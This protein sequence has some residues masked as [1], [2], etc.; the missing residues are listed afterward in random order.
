MK[1]LILIKK[2]IVVILAF[3]LILS[4]LPAAGLTG[5]RALAADIVDSGTCGE[6]LTWT[7]DSDGLLTISGT[8]ATEKYSWGQSPFYENDKIRKV[9]I[10]DG[11]T[12]LE[13]SLFIECP[14]LTA[15]V[16]PDTLTRIASQSFQRTALTSVTIP[17]SV[18]DLDYSAISDSPNISAIDVAP[19]NPVFHS[20]DNCVIETEKKSLHIG[21]KTS[22]IPT[23]GSVI[24][25]GVGAFSVCGCPENVIIPDCVTELEGA[26]FFECG[27]IK[28]LSIGAGVTGIG[29][30]AL[31]RC[32]GL[33][34]ISVAAE[35]TAYRSEDGV[36]FDRDKTELILYPTQKTG[37]AYTIPTGVT[38]IWDE[39][40]YENPYLTSVV[41][42]DGVTEIG[43]YA[44]R[45][46]NLASFNVPDSVI[47]LGSGVFYGSAWY[48]AQPDGVV[49]AG[50]HAC[51]FKGGD[52]P[53]DLIFRDGTRGISDH[54]IYFF[55]EA[56]ETVTIP[57][58]VRYIGEYAFRGCNNLKVLTMPAGA[59]TGKYAFPLD[60][61]ETVTLTGSGDMSDYDFPSRYSE[62]PSPFANAENLRAVTIADGVT[63]VGSY[64][65]ADCSSLE[66]VTLSDTVSSIG[67][68]SFLNCE[69]LKSVKIPSSLTMVGDSA[70][71]G[72]SGLEAVYVADLETW[73]GIVFYS[74]SSNPLFYA[75]K[76]YVG[77]EQL[78]ELTVPSGVTTIGNYAFAGCSGL[79][80]ATI[81]EGVTRIGNHAFSSCED[82]KS[83]TIPASATDVGYNLFE[84]CK[85]LERISLADPAVWCGMEFDYYDRDN[86]L[87]D[88]AKLYVGGEPLTKL[89]IPEGVTG[90]ATYAFGGYTD[91][92]SLTIPASVTVIGRDA[93]RGCTNLTELIVE[94]AEKRSVGNNAFEG[95]PAMLDA[96]STDDTVAVSALKPLAAS[97]SLG[98]GSL[99]ASD[100]VN[101]DAGFRTLGLWFAQDD[102]GNENK[103]I[104]FIDGDSI[105]HTD[106][107]AFVAAATGN[108][109]ENCF[110]ME[111]V[112]A[113]GDAFI[114]AAI[115]RIYG[116]TEDQW[117]YEVQFLRT[118]DGK[119]AERLGS[120]VLSDSIMDNISERN[121]IFKLGDSYILA[122]KYDSFL[123]YDHLILDEEELRES[124]GC[125]IGLQTKDFKTFS[126]FE[127][128]AD[129][130]F[131]QKLA[132]IRTENGS[133]VVTA[134][135]DQLTM[136]FDGRLFLRVSV[137]PEHPDFMLSATPL[138][139]L[140]YA[141]D[142]AD[143]APKLIADE[144]VR[145]DD[146]ETM[147]EPY[148]LKTGEIM[149]SYYEATENRYFTRHTAWD[150][151]LDCY[152]SGIF[153]LYND[154]GN[155]NA[156]LINYQE[157][158]V[159]IDFYRF[160]D[161]APAQKMFRLSGVDAFVKKV[162]YSEKYPFV[163]FTHGILMVDHDKA[164]YAYLN[165]PD[166]S[167]KDVLGAQNGIYVLDTK[168]DAYYISQDEFVFPAGGEPIPPQPTDPQPT[169]PQPTD[170]QPT[171]PQ[172][173]DPPA[174]DAVFSFGGE[175]I[176][177][178]E[179][180]EFVIYA[181]AA[182]LTKSQ[183]VAAITGADNAVVTVK[184]KDG[185][186]LADDA[187]PGTGS[188]V[189]VT[190]GESAVTKTIIFLGDVDGDATVNAT[191]ARLALRAA[192]K[193]DT[194]DGAF[195]SAADTDGD[196]NINATDA[197]GILRAAAK[198][199]VLTVA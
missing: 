105:T 67:Q 183:L 167:V 120:F 75:H 55:G 107:A 178:A 132:E 185:N 15:V 80:S 165:M 54:F 157:I 171:D 10:G 131:L 126:R 138:K 194:L 125:R 78:T 128:K 57:D 186:E 184:D 83:V 68:M 123:S 69:K 158:P 142:S 173:T 109:E 127:F 72:C 81:P 89:V 166:I 84:G 147:I 140:Y 53:S 20:V 199:D 88:G 162:V 50:K 137:W 52:I 28:T 95:V 153:G 100:T 1:R 168:G 49:Y 73:C 76:L 36:L 176:T 23:D 154:K 33:T 93:F 181:S 117:D 113:D 193:L 16:F 159:S 24:K 156:I 160:S 6:N 124:G 119:T 13:G 149:R 85:A 129:D 133:Q 7:L 187:T 31:Y 18:T 195:A 87:A 21:C 134:A 144:A 96:A 43:D 198:L 136:G 161:D 150:L 8:G 77:G 48:D 30:H 44:F 155:R 197:R 180:P 91:L 192:A 172:P 94:P 163:V 101:T 145:T 42:P 103:E 47:R 152:G 141:W 39:A 56:V 60:S 38:R 114:L 99:L 3:A 189:T 112:Y 86:P 70:F 22:L 118:A 188:T 174:A 17:A 79:T 35:N 175:G 82:L 116:E 59:T 196:N 9:V 135:F 58:S 110:L 92:V 4:V 182:A 122:E 191:D 106:A 190:V 32:S 90:I 37:G 111:T 71:D 130:A 121:T 148:I 25:I 34:N 65:F 139:M 61:L 64:A 115:V 169:D 11:V 63:S 41:I 45:C 40:F 51:E 66:R 5:L 26:V 2:H 62:N 146:G 74:L 179:T 177:S 102:K 98:S 143:G 108:P 12:A 19:G 151:D 27:D 164:A 29:K 14:N 97:D 104:V 46:E 170:P